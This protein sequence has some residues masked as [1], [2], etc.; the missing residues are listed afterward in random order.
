[1][2]ETKP[3]GSATTEPT[4]ATRPCPHGEGDACLTCAEIERMLAAGEVPY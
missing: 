4:T 3:T 1:M 2:T